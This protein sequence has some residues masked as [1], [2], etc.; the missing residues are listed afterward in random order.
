[1]IEKSF[2]HLKINHGNG[3]V[4]EYQFLANVQVKSG[5][6]VYRNQRL[7]VIA[8][9]STQKF[10]PGSQEIN[11]PHLHFMLRPT[12]R[13]A[14]F[15]GWQVGYVPLFN[16]TSFSKNGESL[17]LFQLLLNALDLQIVLRGPIT[18]D[19]IYTGSVDTYHHER[20]SF[21]LA[22]TTKFTL[23]ATPATTGF[24]PLLVLLDAN[25]NEIARSAGTMTSTQPAGNYF[26]QVQPQ[27]A[28]G[29]YGLT[30]HKDDLPI[31]TNPY[32]SVVVNPANVNVGESA[33]ATVSLNNVPT[34]GYTSAEFT[35]TYNPNV[36]EASS[37]TVANLFGVDPAVA[38]SGPQNGSFIVAVA[39][40][41]GNKAGTGGTVFTFNAKGLATGQSPIQCAARVS[42]GDSVLTAIEFARRKSDSRYAL[43]ADRDTDAYRGG[44][45]HA[46]IHTYAGNASYT[47]RHI[48]LHAICKRLAH[49]HQHEILVP[50]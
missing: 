23:T 49:V 17:G 15:A 14:T 47:N 45:S 37:I 9:G 27:T 26:V 25:G 48:D 5:D 11:I 34:E 13:N 3:W 39:G 18:W 41:T 20:W 31:P 7:G 4:T 32:A 12:L 10:C 43:R 19:T 2:C 24:V 16:K 21:A 36:V 22:E 33:V 6:I 8:N 42:K 44:T 35:C 28:I 50:A 1:M 40:S 46:D 30:L 38:I 29:F